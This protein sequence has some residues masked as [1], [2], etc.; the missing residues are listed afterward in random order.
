MF[1]FKGEE[2]QITVPHFCMLGN[3]IKVI[4]IC[5]RMLS[6]LVK[7]NCTLTLIIECK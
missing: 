4:H 1:A 5:A 3:S 7:H 6:V 2:V